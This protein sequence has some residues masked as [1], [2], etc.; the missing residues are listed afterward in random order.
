VLLGKRS[1]CATGGHKLR[2]AWVIMDTIIILRWSANKQISAFHIY[3]HY[4]FLLCL[5]VD[6]YITK[7]KATHTR[8]FPFLQYLGL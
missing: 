6:S 5:P 4:T 1:A 8:P 3:E 2:I 7:M